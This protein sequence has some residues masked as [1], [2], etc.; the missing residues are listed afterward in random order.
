MPPAARV[1]DM[2]T[3]P[4]V[5]VVVPHVGGPILPPGAPTVLIDFLPAATV[6]TPATC[7]GPPDVIVK[8]SMGVFI[9]FLPAARMGD[10][11]A[12]GGVI[13][14]GSPTCMIG[15]IGMPSPGVGGFAGIIAG[16]SVAGSDILKAVASVY[17]TS[18]TPKP[19]AFM[20]PVTQ[21]QANTLFREMASK[22]DSIPFDFPK[23]CCYSR[24]HTMCHDLRME[25]VDCGKV[26]NYR[27][28]GPPSG[29]P[30]TVNTPNTPT[31]SVTWGYHVAPIINV[32]DNNGAVQPMVIDPSMFDHPVSVNEWTS[33][34]NAPDSVTQYTDSAPY[35][36]GIDGANRVEDP[37][38]SEAD[39]Q[40]TLHMIERDHQQPIFV[41]GLKDRRE[42]RIKANS[43]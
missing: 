22:A 4:L 20:K 31:G 32:Q 7:V 24:A 9:N 37:D 8:G 39:T 16:L 28:P 33:A 12:H 5:T 38:Y 42:A 10:Q 3:C 1:T 2:H 41:Q 27:N 17:S 40:M 30:L 26:W 25:G 23:D 19:T 15:E 13:V 18:N 6:T 36:R 35:Y 43:N 11:T 14:M 29:P 34:Q 21:E